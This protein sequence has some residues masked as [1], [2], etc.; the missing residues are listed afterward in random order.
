MFSVKDAGG[1]CVR[2]YGDEYIKIGNARVTYGYCN[3]PLGSSS[4]PSPGSTGVKNR[5]ITVIGLG[6]VSSSRGKA[7]V[8][9]NGVFCLTL[10]YLI[11]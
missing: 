1:F 4:G 11:G 9:T 6:R 3:D 8:R 2:L 10:Y 7:Y 5:W